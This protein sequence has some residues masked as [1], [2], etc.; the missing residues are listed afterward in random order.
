M[1]EPIIINF[2]GGL[3]NLYTPLQ[4]FTRQQGEVQ[5]LINA[6][7]TKMGRLKLLRPLTALN[8]TAEDDDV[9]S[10]FRAGDVV[11]VG[12][13]TYLKYVDEATLTSLFTALS[14][15]YISFAHVGDWVFLGDGTNEQAVYLTTPTACDWG[16]NPPSAAPTVADSG[17]AGDPDGTYS[18]YYRYKIT[19]PDGTVI[20]TA[21]S[22]A[23]SVTVVT[24]KIAWSAI[25]HSTFTGATTI[26]AQ[27]FRTKTGFSAT[28]LVTTLASGTTTYTDNVS[29]TTLQTQDEYA[30]TG[31][32]GPPSG[33]DIVTYHEGAD[34]VFCAVDNEV[35][36]SE[37]SL[38]H[39]FIYDED[40]DSYT[41]VNSVFLEGESITCL[42]MFDEQLYIG[43][44]RTWKRLRGTNPDYWMWEPIA[45]AIKGPLSWRAVAVTP[46]GLIYPGNDGH[47]W[48]FNGF[49][50]ARIAE[51][52]VFST[53]PDTTCHATYDGRFYR[54][55]Y[56]DATYPELIL[57]FLEFPRRPPRIIQSTRDATASFYDSASNEFY[58]G[59]SSGYVRNG[60]DTDSDVTLTMQTA[61][62][63][64]EQ[65]ITL[66]N[67][68]SLLIHANT[69][70]VT[71]TIT[72][73]FDDEAQDEI[74]TLRTSSLKRVPIA[75]PFN[76]YRSFSLRVSITTNED[77]ELREPWILRSEEDSVG[78]S[79]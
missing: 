51:G 15:E 4:L 55:F 24:N 70:N 68:G 10:V 42:A 8:S 12:S 57:D 25:V 30:E 18:C 35:Y 59:D 5:A 28:Y 39:T 43:C 76:D 29:D 16:L 3:N 31:Y 23:A 66:G 44:Q 14:G 19:L 26:Q 22:S 6:D 67:A 63:P 71:L 49:E 17:D 11:L 46:W 13:D 58:L 77:I 60:E 52:F 32:Y 40:A 20:Y 65:L 37:A 1:P 41:N 53:D 50:T 79:T 7:T 78:Y 56:G 2:N 36:W 73:Y 45:G 48:I 21:L 72:P 33:V 34:R 74:T 61:E 47:I 9:H 27:L 69:E 62:I 75:M 54:L 64:V 38:Y